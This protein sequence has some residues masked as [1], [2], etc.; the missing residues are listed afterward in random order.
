MI[1]V[2]RI[3]KRVAI[4]VSIAIGLLTGPAARPQ[5]VAIAELGGRAVDPTGTAVSGA[6][7]TITETA[8]RQTR[9]VR[10]DSDGRYVMPNR[11][12]ARTHSK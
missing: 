3:A 7:V 10:T 9:E 12:L 11:M 6:A 4:F 5:A 2:D 1:C 8:K